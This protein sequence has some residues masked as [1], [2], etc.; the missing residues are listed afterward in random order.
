[1]AGGG[2]DVEAFHEEDADADVGLL[3]CEGLLIGVEGDVLL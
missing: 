3:V 1:L 2:V